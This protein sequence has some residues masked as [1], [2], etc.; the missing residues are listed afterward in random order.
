MKK[1]VCV[2]TCQTRL[3]GKITYIPQGEVVDM[4][5]VKGNENC[6]ELLGDDRPVDFVNASE[7][8]LIESD[9]KFADANA[10]MQSNFNTSLKWEEGIKKSDV[11]GQ[12][13]DIRYRHKDMS[14]TKFPPNA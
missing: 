14:V 4:D 2:R 13:M 5:H 3:G 10:A 7:A 6:F 12:I 8:E 9:W 11:V 1:A